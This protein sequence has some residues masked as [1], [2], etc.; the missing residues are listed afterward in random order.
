MS[1]WY[2]V[3]GTGEAA[4]EP[5]ALLEHLR[6]RTPARGDFRGDEQG[7]FRAEFRRDGDGIPLV[8]DRYLTTEDGIRDQLNTWAAWIETAEDNPNHG[9]LMGHMIGTKQLFTLERPDGPEWPD[10]WCVG[11]CQ[12]LARETDGVYQADG[13]G[14]ANADGAV[15]LRE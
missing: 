4:P 15:L 9:P 12:Y 13:V 7:W 14:F 2:R 11:L 10:D 6:L 8:L 1:R 3:F 5:A